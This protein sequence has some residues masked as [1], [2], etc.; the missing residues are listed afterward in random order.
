MTT[1]GFEQVNTDIAAVDKK[2]SNKIDAV[3]TRLSTVETRLQSDIKGLRNSVNNYLKL[4]DK[5][6]FPLSIAP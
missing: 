6:Y 3:E 4:S 2:L 1:R 5:R